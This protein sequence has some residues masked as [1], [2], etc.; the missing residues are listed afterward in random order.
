MAIGPIAV[1]FSSRIIAVRNLL[2]CSG[3]E[4]PIE[5]CFSVFPADGDRATVVVGAHL[6]MQYWCMSRLV[7]YLSP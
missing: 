5:A 3:D 7:A 4:P 1:N 6:S 2:Y